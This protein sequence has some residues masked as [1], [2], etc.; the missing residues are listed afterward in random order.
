MLTNVHV[1]EGVFPVARSYM[2][3]VTF[4]EFDGSFPASALNVEIAQFENDKVNYGPWSFDFPKLSEVGNI[5]VVVYEL[6]TYA[7]YEY[8]TEWVHVYSDSNSWGVALIGD[9]NVARDITIEMYGLDGEIAKTHVV[10]VI[11]TGNI[12][13]GFN[14]E[15]GGQISPSM[16]FTIVGA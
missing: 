8:I 10:K 12:S 15:K 6:N 14:S 9:D 2:W 1:W 4:P 3:D 13:Y 16:A 7:I 5:D 11:P